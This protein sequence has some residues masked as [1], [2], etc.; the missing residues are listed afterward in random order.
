MTTDDPALGVFVALT[1]IDGAGKSTT[2]ARL[3]GL[4]SD[5]VSVEIVDKRRPTV[6]EPYLEKQCQLMIETIWGDQSTVGVGWGDRYWCLVQAAYFALLDEN[7]IAP[8]LQRSQI[9]LIDD[10]HYKFLARMLCKE[11]FSRTFTDAAFA[12]LR[13]PDLVILLDVAPAEAAKRRTVFRA[14]EAGLADGATAISRESFVAYQTRVRREL[15]HLANDLGWEQLVTAGQT[16][17]DVARDAAR[18][19]SAAI[20]DRSLCA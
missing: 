9:V 3:A 4:L 20:A 11:T 5:H 16:P 7:V 10:W 6:D 15:D 18:M 12:G 8:A 13:Q 14:S 17:D 2:A 19:I 1:G